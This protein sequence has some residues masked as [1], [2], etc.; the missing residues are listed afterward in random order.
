M[1]NE[2]ESANIGKVSSRTVKT[3]FRVKGME[4][5]K[6]DPALPL[7]PGVVAFLVHVIN[8]S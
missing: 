6:P 3:F 2:T 5:C 7:L 4:K 8:C 1:V